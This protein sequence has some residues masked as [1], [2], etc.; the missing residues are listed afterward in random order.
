MTMAQTD[1]QSLSALI[2]A[3]DPGDPRNAIRRVD[4]F[5]AQ[6]DPAD[7]PELLHA[8]R[9]LN[10]QFSTLVANALL[11]QEAEEME[12]HYHAEFC[13]STIAQPLYQDC[14]RS[15]TDP[16]PVLQEIERI[17]TELLQ[18]FA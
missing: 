5:G 11:R 12:R 8:L 6:F 2:A 14:P 3:L 13:C 4:D 7:Q 15:W 1:R 17:Q 16:A 10:V 9:R 18:L